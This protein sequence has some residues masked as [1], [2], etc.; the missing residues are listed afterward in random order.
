MFESAVQVVVVRKVREELLKDARVLGAAIRVLLK[1]VRTED[2]LKLVLDQ[3]EHNLKL[4]NELGSCESELLLDQHLISVYCVCVNFCLRKS[5]CFHAEE[6][7]GADL[8]G[9]SPV[10]DV[11]CFGPVLVLGWVNEL[12]PTSQEFEVHEKTSDEV[13]LSIL[14]CEGTQ[15]Q[16]V[17]V[18]VL[19]ELGHVLEVGGQLD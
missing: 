4:L 19:G 8:S 16:T 7:L 6:L 1:G 9:Q 17:D 3:V 12:P 11:P 5:E 10:I 18:V 2:G 15:I 13:L 14:T